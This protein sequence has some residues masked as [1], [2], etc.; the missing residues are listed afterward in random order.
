M[1]GQSKHR[2]LDRIST[3]EKSKKH[4]VAEHEAVV[5]Y[6][7]DLSPACLEGDSTYEDRKAARSAEITALKEAQV[8]LADAFK[9]T[10]DTSSG[11]LVSIRRVRT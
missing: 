11:S 4:T 9:N 8:I 10:T 2:L 7:K 6:L 3:H 5:Q 1:K